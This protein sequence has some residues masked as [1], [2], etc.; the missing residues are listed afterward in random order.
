MRLNNEGEEEG[1]PKGRGVWRWKALTV[2]HCTLGAK[3]HFPSSLPPQRLQAQ[4]HTHALSVSHH[5]VCG[6][7]LLSLCS[8]FG[9]IYILCFII[10]CQVCLQGSDVLMLRAG[11][12]CVRQNKRERPS[13]G[14]S[15]GGTPRA[16]FFSATASACWGAWSALGSVGHCGE[17]MCEF[18][19]LV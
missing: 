5:R 3:I 4:T 13:P 12:P 10:K 8:A 19:M 11:S 1:E 2:S 7:A 16:L 18:S 9:S 14:R 17:W 15:L 6:G